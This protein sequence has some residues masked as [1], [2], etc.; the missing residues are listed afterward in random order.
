ESRPA[1]GLHARLLA[2]SRPYLLFGRLC[3]Q[4]MG[5]NV[6]A[7]SPALPGPRQRDGPTGFPGFEHRTSG[8]QSRSGD[9]QVATHHVQRDN[10]TRFVYFDREENARWLE[11]RARPYVGCGVSAWPSARMP[12]LCPATGWS[13]P[14]GLR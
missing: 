12:E 10:A 3:Y 5:T 14:S 9:R 6:T 13:R 8:T 7:L 4:G 11:D 1:R 2:L